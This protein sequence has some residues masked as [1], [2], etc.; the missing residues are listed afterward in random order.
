LRNDVTRRR[1][2]GPRLL[3]LLRNADEEAD[4]ADLTLAQG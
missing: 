3:D 2:G 4:R 1:A